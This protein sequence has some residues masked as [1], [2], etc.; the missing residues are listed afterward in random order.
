MLEVAEYPCSFE[1]SGGW[2]Q[3]STFQEQCSGACCIPRELE[4]SPYFGFML[5]G[6]IPIPNG[7]VSEE[8]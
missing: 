4:L 8:M 6:I 5:K 2:S 1:K 7:F 3:L